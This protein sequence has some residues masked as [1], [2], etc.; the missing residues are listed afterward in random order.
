MGHWPSR[1]H[2]RVGLGPGFSGRVPAV[3]CGLF[4]FFFFGLIFSMST[5]NIFNFFFF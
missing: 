1:G 5:Q 2:N 3:I 4:R